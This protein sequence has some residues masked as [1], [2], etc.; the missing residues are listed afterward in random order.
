MKHIVRHY[1]MK[2]KYVLAIVVFAVAIGF[3][4]DHCLLRR[5]DQ[6]KE[7]SQLREAINK[8]Q[9]TFNNDKAQLE[10][11]KTNPEAVKRVARERYYMK[12][13]DEDI[14]VIEDE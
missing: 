4:G 1:L 13:P 8:E 12:Q 6:Q 11:L 9:T 14:F 7:I 5:A 3:V 2:Y 10:E